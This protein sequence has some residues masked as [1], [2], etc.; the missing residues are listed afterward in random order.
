MDE[1]IVI[2]R[3]E[4]AIR[5]TL[6]G[7]AKAR[8]TIQTAIDNLDNQGI[9]LTDNILKDLAGGGQEIRASLQKDIEKEVKTFKLAALKEIC[10]K[11]LEALFPLVDEA[12][13]KVRAALTY[14]TAFYSYA[15]ETANFTCANLKVGLIDNLEELITDRH[16]LYDSQDPIVAEAYDRALKLQEQIAEFESFLRV[17]G[18]MV[19]PVGAGSI[20]GLITVGAMGEAYPVTI[21]RA[22]F[23]SIHWK[24]PDNI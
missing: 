17:Y 13:E 3:D 22:A 20:P 11:E 4:E 16:T 18:E 5:N 7:Y 24:R 9:T 6:T 1:R 2:Y 15:L 10:R 14:Q 23:K 21:N 8:N 19:H 12:I